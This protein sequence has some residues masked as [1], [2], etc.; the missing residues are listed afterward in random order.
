METHGFLA[1]DSAAAAREA[2][3]DLGPAAQT[4][5][6]EVAKAM[7]FEREEYRERV[8]EA[9]VAT[10][11]EALFASLLRV[12]VGSAES[13]ETWLEDRDDM[14]VN[15][16]GNEH[17]EQRAWHPVYPADAVAAVTFHEEPDAAIATVRRQAFGRFYRPILELE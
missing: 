7:G 2:F 11:R 1:P 15:L 12:H 16:E 9:V 6:S 5:T 3:E 4:V 13:F 14:T 8:T 17:V 10:G